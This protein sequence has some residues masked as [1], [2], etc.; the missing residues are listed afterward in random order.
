M[1]A[2]QVPI[3]RVGSVGELDHSERN[4]RPVASNEELLYFSWSQRL[5]LLAQVIS[6]CSCSLYP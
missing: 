4:R 3:R 1:E 5:N 6:R 2:E